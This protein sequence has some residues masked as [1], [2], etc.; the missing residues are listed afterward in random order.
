[1]AGHNPFQVFRKNQTFWLAVLTIGAMVSF[2]LLPAV[3]QLV[4]GVS[5]AGPQD[6]AKTRN[7]G[8]VDGRSV[9]VLNQDRDHLRL[10]FRYLYESLAPTVKEDQ[11][12]LLQRLAMC[13]QEFE[14]RVGSE[15]LINDWLLVQYARQVG[16]AAN[17]E[18][19]IS[20]LSGLTGGLLSDALF[21]QAIRDT[22]LPEQRLEYLIANEL[23][24]QQM[25]QSFLLTQS[26]VS[27]AT[28]WD[29]FQRLNRNITA[30]VAAV[31]VDA[32]ISEAGEPADAQLNKLFEEKK[33]LPYSPVSADSGF[34]IPVKLAFQYVVAK[35]S[36]KVLD[37]VTKEEIQKYYDEHK[38]ADFRK[39]VNPMTKPT[40]PG[41]GGAV[42]FSPKPVSPG[43]AGT[44][45][46]KE[47]IKPEEK[48]PEENETS[49]LNSGGAKTIFVKYQAEKPAEP[50]GPDGSAAD[51]KQPEVPNPARQ[52]APAAD[53]PVTDKPAEKPVDLSILYKPLPEVEGQI[54]Q[55]LALQK[56]QAALKPIEEKMREHFQAYNTNFDKGLEVPKM[57]DLTKF[58]EEQ[59]LKLESVPLGTVYDAVKS[60]FCRKPDER[61]FIIKLYRE[62]P[63]VFEPLTTPNGGAALWIT[64]IVSELKP[65][66]VADVKDFVVKRWKETEAA[67][68]ALKRAE[69]LAA[70]AKAADKPLAEIFKGKDDVKVVETEPFAWKSYGPGIHPFIGLMQRLPLGIGEVCEKGVAAGDAEIDNKAIFAPGEEFMKVASS[71]AVGET[72]V[73]FNQPKTVAYVIRAT[74]STPSE[75]VLWE[76][77]PSTNPGFYFQAGM[78]EQQQ[79]GFEA[80]IKQIREET[81]FQW[82]QKPET[83]DRRQ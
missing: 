58:A 15:A 48:K 6:I 36:Q 45:E 57:P 16:Y 28:R 59:G 47:D 51:E 9:A 21:R 67:P 79:D 43:P 29:W 70:E 82:I 10:F 80:W 71:L 25:Y 1:M 72:G 74:G 32:F 44:S 12:H 65:E 41:I 56:A 14:E 27:P 55:I 17:R 38:D 8:K 35:P 64:E 68:L 76:Q 81:G 42:P 62:G 34:E 11:V 30:E 13:V 83:L 73:A 50:V 3:L 49:S 22:G 5:G 2:I 60:E 40:L 75:D 7:F 33:G 63:V 24:R 46:K 20:Y 61:Q 18:S 53:E 54:R 26:V 19:I 78:R 31:P 66:S 77:F 39:P 23:L 37:S 4:S 52:E 69:E